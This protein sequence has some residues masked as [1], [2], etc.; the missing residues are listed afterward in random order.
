[1][2]PEVLLRDPEFL[3]RVRIHS[4]FGERESL[5]QLRVQFLHASRV[6]AVNDLL[7]ERV[8]SLHI[9]LSDQPNRIGRAGVHVAEGIGVDQAGDE[10]LLNEEAPVLG[11]RLALFRGHVSDGR[12]QA[13]IEDFPLFLRSDVELDELFGADLSLSATSRA[14]GV[15]RLFH[16]LHQPLEDHLLAVVLGFHVCLLSCPLGRLQLLTAFFVVKG[17]AT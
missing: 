13:L 17:T 2:V 1:V 9:G 12:V 10:A 8:V 5:D 7:S 6:D 14:E 16:E 4:G 3:D 11:D 15:D